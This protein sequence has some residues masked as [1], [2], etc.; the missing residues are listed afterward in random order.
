MIT[1]DDYVDAMT[2]RQKAK[3][4]HAGRGG[5]RAGSGRPPVIVI[6]TEPSGKSTTYPSIAAAAHSG[7]F[8]KGVLWSYSNEGTHTIPK[9]IHKGWTLKFIKTNKE[10]NV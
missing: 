2:A 9:G 10:A 3:K 6:I 1:V 7:A 5:Y 4:A 8:S